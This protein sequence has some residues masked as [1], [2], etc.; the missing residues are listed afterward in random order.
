MVFSIFFFCIFFILLPRLCP[1]LHLTWLSSFLGCFFCYRMDVCT[2]TRQKQFKWWN[3]KTRKKPFSKRMNIKG[4]LCCLCAAFEPKPF[5]F[6]L[7]SHDTKSDWNLH[8]NYSLLSVKLFLSFFFSVS[9][10]AC[11]VLFYSC[12]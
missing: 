4:N 11:L 1:L 8:I 10:V 3:N 5:Y 9:C 7:S 6:L 12:F 2:H